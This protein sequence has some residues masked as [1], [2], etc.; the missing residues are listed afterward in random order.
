M[1]PGWQLKRMC[2]AGQTDPPETHTVG[3]SS[4]QSAYLAPLCQWL[5]QH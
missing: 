5:F 3:S 4:A 1:H 2:G